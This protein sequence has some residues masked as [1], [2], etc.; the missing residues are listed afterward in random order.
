MKQSL[1]RTLV[2]LPISLLLLAACGDDDGGTGSDDSASPQAPASEA[3]P[4]DDAGSDDDSAGALDQSTDLCS[5]VSEETLA[6]SDL[7]AADGS[8]RD[9]AGLPACVWDSLDRT[10]AVAVD[11]AYALGPIE[12]G[13]MEVEEINGRP[14]QVAYD[15]EMTCFY[16][17]TVD[18][19]TKVDVI[20]EDLG[21][22]TVTPGEPCDAGR[23]AL[24]D[25]MEKTG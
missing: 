25:V 10:I 6:A 14:V 1:K 23:A 13:G 3:A 12:E 24:D 7:T 17:F 19:Q 22:P 18:D 20:V 4:S 16:S 11:F 9:R 21:D 5:L 2:L 15:S 8:Q